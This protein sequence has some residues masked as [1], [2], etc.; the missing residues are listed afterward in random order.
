MAAL[1]PG[2]KVIKAAAAGH[3][4]LLEQP[5]WLA[6]HIIEFT[7][8]DQA[9]LIALSGERIASTASSVCA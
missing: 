2:A 1:N 9:A 4:V 6:V 8:E 3:M 7:A 5:D